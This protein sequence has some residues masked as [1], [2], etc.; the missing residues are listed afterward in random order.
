MYFEDKGWFVLHDF[1]KYYVDLLL[2]KAIAVHFAF[3]QTENK[4]LDDNL[5]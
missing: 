5:I 1:G 4:L 2:G 3:A